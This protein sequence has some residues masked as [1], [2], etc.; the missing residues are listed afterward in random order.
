[1]TKIKSLIGALPIVA[2]AL[3]DKLGV[4]VRISGSE[5]YTDGS[6][7]NIPVLPE[8]SELAVDLARGYLDHEAAHVRFTDFA[9]T[10]DTPFEHHL[11]NLIEDVRIEKALGGV[12]P[13]CIKTLKT[14]S[15]R[16]YPD[17]ESQ[18]PESGEIPPVE[19]FVSWLGSKFRVEQL[20]HTSL[21]ATFEDGQEMM[22]ELF[23]PEFLADTEAIVSQFP[24]MTSTAEVKQM[25]KSICQL[26]EDWQKKQQEAPQSHPQLEKEKDECEG[27]EGES[28]QGGASGN[29]GDQTEDSAE[30]SDNDS[31]SDSSGQDEA[32]SGSDSDDVDSQRGASGDADDQGDS[33]ANQNENSDSSV[34]D[35]KGSMDG[36]SGNQ[37]M[38]PSEGET[39]TGN[40]AG[41]A[42]SLKDV[43]EAIQQILQAT[44]NELEKFDRSQK[45]E[46]LLAQLSKEGGDLEAGI[47]IPDEETPVKY[48][49][50]LDAPLGATTKL[51]T[52]L[53]G[54]VQ[55]SKQTRDLPRRNGRLNRR[56]LSGL[57]TGNTKIFAGHRE[58]VGVNTAV[59]ILVDRSGSMGG[60]K[61][62]VARD[63]ALAASIALHAISGVEV[64][65]AAFPG[66]P[67]C[68]SVIPMT[69]FGQNPKVTAGH[70]GL[71]ATGSTPMTEALWWSGY[72]L[73]ARKEPRKILLVATDG[74]PDFTDSAM[75]AIKR[76]GQEGIEVMGLGI[77]HDG[78][79]N[80][81][82][83]W[84][85]INELSEMPEAL[86]GMLKGKLTSW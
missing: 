46:E 6:L 52:R 64:A 44:A 32:G 78:V 12:F 16:L 18:F 2:K 77:Q 57:A 30:D 79:R 29:A 69:R 31:A 84:H 80:L 68:A 83:R 8:D 86:F 22:E 56:K 4:R 13:G 70:Y 1:M 33:G 36:G 72:Q 74:E 48:H 73:L 60:L 61:M 85:V 82:P 54:L 49:V 71:P 23:P 42:P 27:K 38:D 15:D 7:I 19:L 11:C 63:S 41:T 75:E 55:A 35:T 81:F 9:F 43:K 39:G 5:A 65:T 24:S 17:G 50:D 76:L 53:Q 20:A 45:V 26:L 58:K 47:V 51:R 59:M 37:S 14:L 10:G 3:G 40:G 62:S 25:A 34:D 28:Q 67:W 66:G 21:Q